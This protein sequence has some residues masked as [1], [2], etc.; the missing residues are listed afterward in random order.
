MYE[1][2]DQAT[3]HARGALGYLADRTTDVDTSSAY[4]HVLMMLDAFMLDAPP[5]ASTSPKLHDA[6]S[7]ISV[8]RQSV[9]TLGTGSLSDLRVELLLTLLDDAATSDV[10]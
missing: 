9:L 3:A 10:G 4:E 1:P 7:A 2:R 6:R 8:V 5:S